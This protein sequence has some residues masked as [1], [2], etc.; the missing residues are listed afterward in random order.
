[1]MEKIIEFIKNDFTIDDLERDLE[2]GIHV[3]DAY[4][5][6]E[7]IQLHF[8]QP[9][10]E[11][12]TDEYLDVAY[13]EIMLHNKQ[14]IEHLSTEMKAFIEQAIK[15]ITDNQLMLMDKEFNSKFHASGFLFMA[16]GELM[17]FNER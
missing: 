4:C 16:D 1:M 12:D 15:C 11:L 14:V 9:L 5:D 17:F 3:L 2:D 6:I 10:D 8:K 13:N 7:K